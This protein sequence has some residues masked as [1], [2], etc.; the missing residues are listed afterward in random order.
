MATAGIAMMIGRGI[1]VILLTSIGLIDQMAPLLASRY[2]TVDS[3]PIGQ[4][5]H[6]AIVDK[7]VG[8][9]LAGEVGI[10]ISGLLRIVAIGGIELNTTLATPLKGLVQELALTAGPEDEAMAIGNEH[11][12]R[13]NG[14][15]ALLTYLGIFILDNRTVEIYCYNHK[16]NSQLLLDAVVILISI[17]R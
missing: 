14:E 2:H 17:V 12:Q 15:G 5:A 11:L 3:T 8:L 16:F 6:I 10:I 1:I 4:S 9:Q 13:L 7:E